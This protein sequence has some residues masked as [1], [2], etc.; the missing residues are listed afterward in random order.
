MKIER[1]NGEQIT[2]NAPKIYPD[3][4]LSY[5]CCLLAF[6]VSYA[7]WHSIG[8]AILHGLLGIYYLVYYGFY[9]TTILNQLK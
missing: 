8:Y 4:T 9:Y 2:V 6:I 5:A 7:K 1:K 3:N